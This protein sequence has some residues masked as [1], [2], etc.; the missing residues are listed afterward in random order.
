MHKRVLNTRF[1]ALSLFFTAFFTFAAVLQGAQAAAQVIFDGSVLSGSEYKT[2]VG[3]AFKLTYVGSQQKV[4]IDLPGESIIIENNSCET[5]K[6]IHG[7]FNGATFV[8][9]NYS[10]PDRL[11]YEYKIKLSLLAP[12]IQVNSYLDRDEINVGEEATVYVNIT[13]T[14]TA[15][16]TVYFS[17]KP[18]GELKIIELPYQLCQLSANNTLSLIKDM[19]V[20]E[21]RHCDYKV[22]P[23]SPGS[24]TLISSAE[25]D[26]ITRERKDAT[27]T[28]KVKDLP[29]LI[30]TTLDQQTV[31]LGGQLN[32]TVKLTPTQQLDAFEFNVFLPSQL[33]LFSSSKTAKTTKTGNLT[34]ISYGDGLTSFKDNITLSANFT[35]KATGE[36]IVQVSASWRFN[37]SKQKIEVKYPVNV[38]FTSPYFRVV[39]YDQQAGRAV[40]EVVNPG[41]LPINNVTVNFNSFAEASGKA[42]VAASID[43]LSYARFTLLQKSSDANTTGTIHYSTEYGQKLVTTAQLPI[44]PPKVAVQAPAENTSAENETAEPAAPSAQEAQP[45]EPQP[46]PET[47]PQPESESEAGLSKSTTGK[48]TLIT[49]VIVAGVIVVILIVVMAVIGKK[50]QGGATADL[51]K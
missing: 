29:I 14:G 38:T 8:G 16:G 21:V 6:K 31:P 19:A 35:A 47:A 48:R 7:C 41:H 37:G 30:N 24:Y 42:L 15:S 33:S 28:L 26:V 32:L 45:S 11:V 12:D 39:S 2:T 20:G 36:L 22:A 27:S 34:K 10:L 9:Y 50:Q 18:L 13:N 43:S 40:A 4:I 23:S 1:K 5:G 46:A 49:G 44:T 25:F 3:D 51:M 17:A